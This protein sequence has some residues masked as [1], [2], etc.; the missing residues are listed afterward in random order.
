[1]PF[2]QFVATLTGAEEVPP[3]TTI[4]TGTSR[5]GFDPTLTALRVQTIVS[6]INR[7]TAA[8]IH[9]GRPG[10]N[11][12]VIAFLYGPAPPMDFGRNALLSD[13][14][15]TAANLTGPMTGRSIADLAREIMAGNTYVNVHTVRNPNG[16]IR[17]QIVRL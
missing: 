2:H 3:V 6:M 14:V 4:A 9:L 16:E 13:R 12:P 10:E 15:I 17:G 1:M 7:V 5:L 8:H 11:G